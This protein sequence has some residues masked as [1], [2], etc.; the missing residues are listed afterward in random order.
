RICLVPVFVV[1]IISPWP[2]Y[3]PFW[4]DA[5]ASKPWI[6]AGIFILLAAT[7]G[8]DGYLARS[9]GEVTNFGKFIDPLADKILVAAALLALIELGVLPSWVALV[10]LTREFIVSGIRMV[11]A[12]Q[13]VVIAASWYG[14]AKTVAQIVA[15]VLFIVKDSLTFTTAAG[16]FT[17]PMFVLSHRHGH[18]AILTVMSMLDYL[19]KARHLLKGSAGPNRQRWPPLLRHPPR[20][21]RC[22]RPST[23]RRASSSRRRLQGP[24]W[25]AASLTG[26]LV[27]AMLTSVPGRRPRRGG[28]VSY[29][30][31]VKAEVLGVSRT[32]SRDR[33]RRR[34][35]GPAARGALRELGSDV[36]WRSRASPPTAPS[37]QAG[38]HGG[39]G[40]ATAKDPCGMPS[41]RRR[42]RGRAPATV[43]I[44]LRTMEEAS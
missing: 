4:A 3:F 5:E 35:G 13:G 37:P 42:P 34:A 15:I 11:A 43:L 1:A 28:I 12:S 2:E 8:L 19:V 33:G 24:R 29:V 10:I 26:G 6:A 23:S 41:F 14:K 25:P 36:R 18:R 21:R 17:N 31:E 39:I 20:S 44:A 38:G 9:R 30:N 27:A 22:R 7:D 32:C 40:C 16:A